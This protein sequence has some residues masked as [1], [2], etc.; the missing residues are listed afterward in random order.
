MSASI[1]GT[2]I[3]ILLS[4]AGATAVEAQALSDFTRL[5][6]R[7][8]QSVRAETRAGSRHVGKLRSV[9]DTLLT[10][11]S[12][13]GPIDLRPADVRRLS[14]RRGHARAAALTGFGVTG[15]IVLFSECLASGP[16]RECDFD[17]PLIIGGGLGALVGSAIRTWHVVY[18]DRSAAASAP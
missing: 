16:N 5:K 4:V 11:S 7:A 18:E 12:D 10:L 9:S 1:R 13:A 14:V 2:M 3:L 17:I 6:L 15:S 8:G